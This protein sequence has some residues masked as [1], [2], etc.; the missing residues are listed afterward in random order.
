MGV[1]GKYWKAVVEEEQETGKGK[2]A[3]PGQHFPVTLELVEKERK[4]DVECGSAD[5]PVRVEG[6]ICFDE[7]IITGGVGIGHQEVRH[8]IIERGDQLQ[9]KYLSTQMQLE[10]RLAVKNFLPQ[11]RGQYF[12]RWTVHLIVGRMDG[13]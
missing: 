7:G 1:E 8:D 12:T 6:D 4:G 3:R 10:M 11:N 13:G 2:H 5:S 9:H